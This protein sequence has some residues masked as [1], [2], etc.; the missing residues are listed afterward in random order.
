MGKLESKNISI[1]KT[2]NMK[3]LLQNQNTVKNVGKLP[4]IV[5]YLMN[6][7]FVYALLLYEMKLLKQMKNK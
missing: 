5:P 6:I 1:L 3:C 4:H 7:V 2:M